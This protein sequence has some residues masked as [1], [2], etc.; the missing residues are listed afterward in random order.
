M[1]FVRSS[2]ATVLALL[3]LLQIRHQTRDKRAINV[4][5]LLTYSIKISG[6]LLCLGVFAVASSR[7]LQS[8]D[9]LLHAQSEANRLVLKMWLDKKAE[10]TN[11]IDKIDW[12]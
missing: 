1:W 2:H 6:S 8:V 3:K 9:L 5:H 7:K 11:V 10:V 4:R 12:I